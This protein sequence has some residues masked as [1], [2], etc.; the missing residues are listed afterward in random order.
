MSAAVTDLFSVPRT[1]RHDR[2]DGTVL[3]ESAEPLGAYPASAGQMLR[4][5]ARRDPG[6]TLIAE[7][8]PGGDWNR[9]S[10]G[11]HSRG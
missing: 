11:E 10:Y 5:W 2:A 4:Y 9:C 7:R 1:I 3:V 6:R 8:G